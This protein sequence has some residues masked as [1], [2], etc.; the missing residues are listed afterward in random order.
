MTTPAPAHSPAGLR[1]ITALAIPALV[2]LAAEPL[3]ILVDTAVVGHLGRIP[4]A[5][6]ALGGGVMSVAGWI[7]VVLAYGTTG[8]VAR[9]F[10]AGQRAE[11][12]AEGVQGSWLAVL[13][14]AVMIAVVQLFAG[15]LTRA[16]AGGGAEGA[17]IAAAAE[18]WL[19]IAVFGAPFLLLAMAGQ[20][21]MRG[22]QDTRRPMY[23]VLAAS[24]GSAI[25]AP[26]LVYP[27]GLGLI[28]S[29]IANVVAQAVSGTLF[30]RALAVEGV[31]L[32]PRWNVVRRQLS[33]SRDLVIRGGAFQLCFISAAAVAARF[34]AAALAAHQIGLQLWFFAALALDAVAIAAQAL[35]GAELGGGDIARAKDTARRI[36][37]IGLGYGVFFAVLVGIGAPF[38]PGLFSPDPE[39]ADQAAVL[40]PWFIGLLPVAGVVFA[41]D[42]VFIGAGDVAFMRN[43][44]VLAALVGFLPLIWLTYA[45]DAGLGGIW[46]GL[47]AF[48]VVRLLALLWRLRSGTWAIAG[49]ER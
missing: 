7:G 17:E 34:G 35:I 48:I 15:P 33:L 3:Y 40:W 47:S 26:I 16:L 31:S 10:G 39:V 25:L 45:F 46:A 6:L 5:A 13:G 24:I 8:R 49:A 20:G 44:T 30:I 21:W 43:M 36:G 29:A 37:W 22:V 12:V 28:G 23:I 32:R 11:A 9:R 41:L 4:L 18:S 14:G 42:G 2:V 27:V 19:R 38:L 1:R